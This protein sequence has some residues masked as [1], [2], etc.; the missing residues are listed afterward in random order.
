MAPPSHGNLQAWKRRLLA[1]VAESFVATEALVM[2]GAFLFSVGSFNQFWLGFLALPLSFTLLRGAYTLTILR[3]H[4]ASW[5][6]KASVLSWT[7]PFFAAWYLGCA[8]L[9]DDLLRDGL[10]EEG[11]E[12]RVVLVACPSILLVINVVLLLYHVMRRTGPLEGLLRTGKYDPRLPCFEGTLLTCTICLEDFREQE[13][14][15]LLP[16]GHLFHKDCIRPWLDRDHRCPLRCPP[17]P[18]QAE[19]RLRAA[20][21]R[22]PV[23]PPPQPA[24]PLRAALPS[25]MPPPPLG[26]A[27]TLGEEAPP[28]SVAPDQVQGISSVPHS[29]PGG[30]TEVSRD[31]LEEAPTLCLVLARGFHVEPPVP[32]P[33]PLGD[34]PTEPPTMWP[35][36]ARGQGASPAIVD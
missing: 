11:I 3:S 34:L 2:Q 27:A 24:E 9:M 30:L 20:A 22:P 32:L 4:P 15:T 28:V 8:L 17:G 21:A 31:V 19:S 10:A 18:C 33:T 6:S 7:C 29:E 1:V 36:A 12:L 35:F 13:S 16:C 5:P 26:P 23:Q 14:V 25:A